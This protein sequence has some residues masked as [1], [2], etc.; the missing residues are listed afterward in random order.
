MSNR[1]IPHLDLSHYSKGS[2]AERS[3]FVSAWGD[4]LKEFGLGADLLRRREI[5]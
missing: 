3:R 5:A 2:A 4:G 1:H